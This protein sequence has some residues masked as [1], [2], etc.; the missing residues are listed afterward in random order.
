M[1]KLATRL[2]IMALFV[3]APSARAQVE[4]YSTNTSEPGAE[5]ENWHEVTDAPS[6][7]ALSPDA[8]TANATTLCL[9][10]GRF[11]ARAIFSAPSLGIS[12]APAQA[13]PLT[14][15]TGYFWFFSANNVE[16]TLKVVDGRTFNGFF[17]AFYAALSDVAYTITITDMDTGAVK[18]YS[19]AQ[20]TLASVADVTAFPGTA[21]TCTYAVSP[22]TRSVASGGGTG[23]FSVATGAGCSWTASSNATYISIVSGGSGTGNG[24]VTFS[25][26]PNTG[27]SVRTGSLNVAG[28]LVFVEQA[29]TSSGG[30]DYNGNWNGTTSQGRAIS[31]TIANN[32]LQTFSIGYSVSGG[33]CSSS[34]TSTI[35]YNTPPSVSGAGFVVSITGVGNPRLS[36]TATV[37]FN[38]TSSASGNASFTFTQTAP[39]PARN[40]TGSATFSLTKS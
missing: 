37:N 7:V 13:V 3:L 36:Y 33:G 20:G 38:S 31:F 35:T 16:I 2:T 39:L 14:G 8:C 26:S 27:T 30:S 22:Q 11:Q 32:R 40:A 34:G 17:W 24:T 12:N 25:V 21:P 15:D 28:Q 10:N 29:G 6:L 19:N 9:N 5:I 4:T 1:K 18:T 23:T